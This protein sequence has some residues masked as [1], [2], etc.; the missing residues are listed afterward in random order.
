MF[1]QRILLMGL[2]CWS[3]VLKSSLGCLMDDQG[4]ATTGQHLD[5]PRVVLKIPVVS[6]VYR[7]IVSRVSNRSLLVLVFSYPPYGQGKVTS[8]NCP[9]S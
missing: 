1:N 9:C 7:E 2:P 8:S 3:S 4:E 5:R 6:S